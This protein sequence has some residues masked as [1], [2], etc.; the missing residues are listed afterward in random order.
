[1]SI[2]VCMAE[3]GAAIRN[4]AGGLAIRFD[5]PAYIRAE[6]VLVDAQSRHIGLVFEQGY[7]DLGILP[8][9]I[10]LG[11]LSEAQLSGT[12]HALLLKA[13]VKIIQ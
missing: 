4:V 12:T 8:D 1:M 5:D 10:E 9:G 13:P 2:I 6:Q 11:G 7:H 3:S